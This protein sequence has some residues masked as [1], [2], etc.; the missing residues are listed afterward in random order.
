MAEQLSGLQSRDAETSVALSELRRRHIDLQ[1]RVLRVLVR[2]ECQRKLGFSLQPEEEQLRVQ[3]DSI[4][5]QLAVPTQFRVRSFLSLKKK[6]TS[7]RVSSFDGRNGVHQL[8]DF[9]CH[10]KRPTR[11]VTFETFIA[12]LHS[13]FVWTFT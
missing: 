7:G 8:V 1:H 3:L 11:H 12:F 4:D 9:C 6:R 13:Q 2:Q 10:E 5:A